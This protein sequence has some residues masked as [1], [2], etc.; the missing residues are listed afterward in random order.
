MV[1][2]MLAGYECLQ[3]AKS[4]HVA[5]PLALAYHC[6]QAFRWRQ[7]HVCP[8]PHGPSYIEWSLCIHNRVVFLVHDVDEH[9][10]YYRTVQASGSMKS[11]DT[12]AWLWDYLNL[13]APT[14]TWY[15]EWCQRDPIFAKHAKRFAGVSILRQ[16]PWECM[17]AYVSRH[18]LAASY[19]APTTTSRESV[20]WCISCVIISRSQ[21]CIIH[22][23]QAPIS[24]P[25]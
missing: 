3:L 13:R 25:P 15:Q 24:V 7:V 21:Y 18:L 2:S 14:S 19:A 12:G 22:I 1:A 17:C 16:D 23:R 6:G 9:C 8:D 10:L 11:H 4:T 5:L 20:K